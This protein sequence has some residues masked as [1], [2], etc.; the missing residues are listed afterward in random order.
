[1]E[2]P[3]KQLP[4]PTEDEVLLCTENTRYE[5]VELLLRRALGMFN[6]G[7]IYCLV[8]ADRLSYDVGVQVENYFNIN[9]TKDQ[10]MISFSLY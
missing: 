7:K 4:L 2:G 3:G 5:E 1:M 10:S 8:N 6:H 9:A